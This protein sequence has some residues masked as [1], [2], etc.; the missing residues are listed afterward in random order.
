MNRKNCSNQSKS[1]GKK[2]DIVLALKA[3]KEKQ[4]ELY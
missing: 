1:R 4:Q 2:A 3:T